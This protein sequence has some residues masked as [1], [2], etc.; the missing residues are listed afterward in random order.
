[1]GDPD[2]EIEDIAREWAKR[3]YLRKS[4]SG[5]MEEECIKSVWE[6]VLFE[7]DLKYRM[8]RGMDTDE[9]TIKSWSTFRRI[10]RRR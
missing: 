10:R 5:D 3:E 8:L 7:G 4:I 2:V 1:M 6:R 9:R